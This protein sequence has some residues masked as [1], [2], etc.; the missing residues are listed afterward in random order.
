MMQEFVYEDRIMG[1]DL[2]V[3]LVMADARAANALYDQMRS[4]AQRYDAQF[5]RFKEES[6]LSRLNRAG[7]L[8]VTPEFLAVLKL[9]FELYEKT[10]RAFNPLVDISRFGYDADIEEVQ[11]TERAL[12][13]NAVPYDT[14]FSSVSIDWERRVVRLA[15]GQSLDVGGYLKGYVA[16]KLCHDARSAQGVIVNLGG[17]IATAGVDAEGAPFQFE[18][19][20]PDGHSSIAFTYGDGSI[21]TSGSYRR[22]WTAGGTPFHHILDASGTQNPD[23]EVVSATVLSARGH[24]AE[25]YATAAFVLGREKAA[26]LLA[27]RGVPYCLILKGGSIAASPDFSRRITE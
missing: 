7:E 12:T 2:S 6:E 8:A 27:S 15:P 3:S 10:E 9:G 13:S 11:G 14:D 18:V 5:S 25:G 17:D 24:D 16:E 22:H 20:R 1:C 21:A 4:R 23:T 26:A 19:E